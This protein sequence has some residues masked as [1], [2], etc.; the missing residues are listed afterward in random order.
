[1]NANSLPWDD[2]RTLLAI[3]STGSLN[4]AARRLGV[5]HATVFRRL[6]A[7]EARLGASLFQRERTGYTPTQAGEELAAVAARVD[8]DIRAAERR[9]AGLDLQPTGNIGVTTT[10]TLLTGLLSPVFARFQQY[11]PAIGLEVAV[12]NQLFSLARREAE[13]AIRPTDDPPESLIGRRVGAISLAV[14]GS[15]EQARVAP[16][17][18]DLSQQ[19]WVGP[20][21]R[22]GYATLQAWM[23]THGLDA[24][25]RYRTDTM[26]GM[27]A[28]ITQGIG[29]GVLPCYLAEPM[30]ELIRL[31][32]PIPD[33]SVGLW[34]L[35][36]PDL[37]GVARI[38]AFTD[39]VTEE[40]RKLL[41]QWPG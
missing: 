1:M 29:V 26:L 24:R 39:F 4:G 37:R 18:V 27:L 10:D 25:C 22:M 34:T 40:T 3:A 41:Q 20:D 5:S 30:P 2:L 35:S 36:H 21:E 33:L 17:Y 28:A 9:V 15:R 6:N 32:E 38:K 14:Y 16:Q 11:Y 12:S 13:V 7:M 8:E 31:S 19:A 23:R